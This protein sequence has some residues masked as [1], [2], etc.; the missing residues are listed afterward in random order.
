VIV[1]QPAI[2]ARPSASVQKPDRP[3]NSASRMLLLLVGLVVVTAAPYL[4]GQVVY[5]IRLNQL[6]AGVD[7]ATKTLTGIKPELRDFE[8]ASRMVAKRMEPSVVSIFRPGDFGREGQG[9]G[10]IVDPA[11]YI[12]TNYHVVS[13]ATSIQVQLSDGRRTD[14]SVVGADEMLDLAV[15][16]IELPSLIAAEWGDS[17]ELEVGDMVWA[18]GSPYGLDRSFSFGIVSAKARRSESGLTRYAYQEYLQTDAA[19]NPGNSGGPLMNIGGQVIGI[20]TAILGLAYQGISFAIPSNVAKQEYDQLRAK[21]TIERAWLG[22]RPLEVPKDVQE[23]FGLAIGQG[24]YVDLVER[25]T[26]AE[27]AG[28]RPGDVILKWND[29]VATDPTLLSRAIAATRIG[30]IAK[31]QLTRSESR[32]GKADTKPT[33]IELNVKVE[34][35]TWSVPPGESQPDSPQQ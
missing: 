10:V 21:G 30:S 16:K 5:Q 33:E 32:D 34:R 28:I 12:M 24:V 9:S 15:L 27:R 3:P 19:V 22:I 2:A 8:L 18:V 23:R 11:G 13:G 29:F 14:A 6:Q 4:I 17:D 25:K 26:P 7:V 31:V 1:S 35:R 20:N